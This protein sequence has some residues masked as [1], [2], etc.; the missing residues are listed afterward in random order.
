[1][2]KPA[3]PYSVTLLPRARRAL[4]E[5]IPVKYV[6]VI[7]AFIEGPLRENPYRVGKL[8]AEPLAPAYSAR[9]GPYRIVYYIHDDQVLI[10]VVQIAHRAV[11]YRPD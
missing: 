5:T 3:G 7:M 2:S 6:S 1:M 4:T 11:V 9:R 8:L 10:E